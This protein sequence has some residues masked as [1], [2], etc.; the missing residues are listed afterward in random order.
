M[1]NLTKSK[2]LKL[3]K[4]ERER[5]Y[6]SN[7]LEN[8]ILTDEDI[9]YLIKKD[10]SYGLVE[11]KNKS[12][13][14]L[15]DIFNCPFLLCDQDYLSLNMKKLLPYLLDARYKAEQEELNYQYKEGFL[16]KEELDK[17]LDELLFVYYKS[18][19]DGKNILKTGHVVDVVDNK[20]KKR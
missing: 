19:Q 11:T 14:Y 6:I 13:L 15:K 12:K 10:A 3:L 20:N 2:K 5:L 9:L 8:N 16:S 7:L 18:S 1:A 17:Q 4:I